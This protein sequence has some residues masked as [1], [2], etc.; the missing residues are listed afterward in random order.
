VKAPSSPEEI[1][2]QFVADLKG[3]YGDQL[4]S[5]ILYG[6]GA[7][8]EYVPGKS[9]INFLVVV[10]DNSIGRL[11]RSIPLVKKWAKR[12]VAVPLFL[13]REYI[14]SSLDAFPI[15]FLVMK[16]SHRLVYGEDILE[17]IPISPSDLRL[18][19]ERELKG[20]LLRLRQAFLESGGKRKELGILVSESLTAFV[21]IFKALLFIRGRGVPVRRE[22]IFADV[23]EEFEELD[24]ELFVKLLKWRQGLYKPSEREALELFSSY[25]SQIDALAK[26]VDEM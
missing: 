22:D 1:F 11:E 4:I 26:K 2:D 8:G 7:T 12:R 25:V 14:E 6:S 19:C 3:I 23:S 9:D 10:G 21:S 13:T 15:E 24:G 5:V 16:L 17:D 20:K 18:Q